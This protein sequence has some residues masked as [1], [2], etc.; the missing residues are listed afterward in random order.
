MNAARPVAVAR[1]LTALRTDLAALDLDGLVVT[2]LPNL[3]YLTGFSAT[4]GAAVV[5][6]SRCRLVIDFRYETTARALVADL[7]SDLIEVHLVERTYDDALVDV[8]RG[9]G[10][11]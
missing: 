1:R 9:I 4:A 8:L 2:H 7:P 6:G 3:R 5:S 10:S 11:G